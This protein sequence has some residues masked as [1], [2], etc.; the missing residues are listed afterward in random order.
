MLDALA[1]PEP[2]PRKP[3]E[4]VEVCRDRGGELGAR[5]LFGRVRSSACVFAKERRDRFVRK[6]DAVL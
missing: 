2:L 6:L 4:P 5:H 1:E 3:L